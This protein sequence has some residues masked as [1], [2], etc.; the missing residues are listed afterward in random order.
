MNPPEC[1]FESE[2]I[3]AIRSGNWPLSLA[4]HARSCARCQETVEVMSAL[5]Q[6]AKDVPIPSSLPNYRLIWMKAQVLQ[7]QQKLNRIEFLLRLSYA[8]IGILAALVIG[9]WTFS[10]QEPTG[11][12][13]GSFSDHWV[14]LISST[15][16]YTATGAAIY[17][18]RLFMHGWS[19]KGQVPV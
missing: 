4:D 5:L 15:L 16:P 17:V 6:A 7:K 10:L 12:G 3:G 8:A 9:Y 19:R 14:R 1:N 11:G 13:G 2:V 18:L